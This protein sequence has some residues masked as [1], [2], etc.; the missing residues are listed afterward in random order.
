MNRSVSTGSCPSSPTITS[1][2]IFAWGG[3]PPRSRRQSRRNGQNRSDASAASVVVKRT[4]NDETSAK[5]G[6]W[7]DVGIRRRWCGKE[8]DQHERAERTDTC[9][10]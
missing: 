8:Q 9:H 3:R 6:A 7:A 1:R 10:W 5:P 2:R 4:R